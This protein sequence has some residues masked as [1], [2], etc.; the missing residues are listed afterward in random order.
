MAELSV[1]YLE[2]A[3]YAG[4][5]V[6]LITCPQVALQQACALAEVTSHDFA[7]DLGCGLGGWCIEAAKCGAPTLGLDIN[8]HTLRQAEVN[9]EEAG[10][11]HMCTFQHCD[12]TDPEFHLPPEV[13]VLF[14]YLLPWALDYLELELCK[15]LDRGGRF[16]TFQFHPEKLEAT[17]VFLFGA[18]KMYGRMPTNLQN[19]RSKDLPKDETVGDH[20]SSEDA[21]AFLDTM[22]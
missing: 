14:M 5:F 22:D 20:E 1:D 13:T 16:V 15:F 18:L 9:A 21:K 8:L 12:F 17:K 4:K 10:V 19:L 11:A 7:C 3:P 6:P 2:T